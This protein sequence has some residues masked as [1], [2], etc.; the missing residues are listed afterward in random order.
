MLFRLRGVEVGTR[1]SLVDETGAEHVYEVIGRESITKAVLPVDQIF[2]REG[3]HRL[4]VITC[5]GE[6]LP[7]LRSYSDNVVVTAVPVDPA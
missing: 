2:A 4:V 5:G 6:F 7:E 3:E 1:L